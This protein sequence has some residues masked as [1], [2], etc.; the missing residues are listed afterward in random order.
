M[1]SKHLVE[2]LARPGHGAILHWLLMKDPLQA[3]EG[4][5]SASE[6]SPSGGFEFAWAWAHAQASGARQL[7]LCEQP[8]P[9]D[10]GLHYDCVLVSSL[11][12]EGQSPARI[13][14]AAAGALAPGGQLVALLS[15]SASAHEESQS[16][17]ALV[18][19]LHQDFK[20]AG[21]T[22]LTDYVGI[23][24]TKRKSP[25]TKASAPLDLQVVEALEQ[26]LNSYSQQRV[27]DLQATQNL[28]NKQLRGAQR[29]LRK[30][31][32]QLLESAQAQ[33]DKDAERQQLK[34]L[35]SDA[36]VRAEKVKKTLS[37]RLGY[38][39]I[40]RTK[41]LRGVVSLP[42]ALWDVNSEAKR[43]RNGL[44][45]LDLGRKRLKR[46]AQELQGSVMPTSPS[47][48]HRPATKAAKRPLKH[49]EVPPGLNQLQ[50]GADLAKLRVASIMDEFT[51]SSFGPEC[52]V[53]LLDPES[54]QE[55]LAE[56]KPQLLF[57][58]S[59]WRGKDEEW[60]GKI[61]Q[62]SPELE[63][64]IKWSRER[65]NIPTI[66]WCKED[67]VH[68][69][70]FINTA[71]HFDFVFT[72]DI[73]CVHRYKEILGHE[74]IYLLP[75]ACQ[76]KTQ[77][78]I[79]K[80]DRKNAAC[81]AG[82]YY[83]RYPER[84][85]DFLRLVLK[86]LE[87]WP[88]EIFDRN[89][90]K[91]DPGYQFPESFRPL[92]QGTLAFSEI[93]RAYKGYDYAININSIKYSQTMFA[94]RVFEVLASNTVTVSNFSRGIQLMF[95][96]LVIATDDP[97]TLGSRLNAL[98]DNAELQR[99]FK[100]LGLRKVLSEH[101]YQD[102]LAYVAKKV[103]EIESPSLLPR[104]A[105]IG[106]AES[107][108]QFECIVGSFSRQ[109]YPN[110]RLVLIRSEA[111]LDTAVE[112]DDTLVTVI[113]RRA[114]ASEDLTTLFADAD[115]IASFAPEDFYGENY[116]VDLGLATRFFEGAAIGKVARYEWANGQ[117]ATLRGEGSQYRPTESLWARSAIARPKCF[118]A[119]SI[120][121][122]VARAPSLELKTGDAF[123]IDEFSYCQGGGAHRDGDAL[124]IVHGR[125]SA[126]DGGL[127]ISRL[128]DE[129]EKIEPSPAT[130]DLGGE[131]GA[132]QFAQI[133]PS[134]RQDQLT[135]HHTTDGM[136]V[137]SALGQK[138]SEYIYAQE[139]VPLSE[140][141]WAGRA[142]FYLDVSAGA[143]AQVAL[144][145]YD[146]NEKRLGDTINSSLSNHEVEIPAEARLVL[147]GLLISG[148]GQVTINRLM[149]GHALAEDPVR[150]FG[151]S[152]RLVLTNQYPSSADLY[153]N[154][155]VHRRVIKY[156]ERGE[157]VDV[158]RF[159]SGEGLSYHDFEGVTVTTGGEEIL[160]R[161]L[162]TNEYESVLVHFL[163]PA[164]WSVLKSRLDT[165]QVIVWVHGFEIQAWHRR[166]YN[167]ST[168]S[169]VE[170][171]KKLGERR[172]LLWHEV[173]DKVHPNLKLVFVSRHLADEV[174][175][176]MK[177]S[178]PT[179]QVHV[180]HNLIDT[181]LFNYVAKP[182]EQRTQVLS[183]RPF[184]DLTYAN[185]LSVAAILELSD[186]PFFDE[187]DFRIIGDGCL[188]DE[189]VAPLRGF[190]NVI[191]EKR[192]IAQTEITELHKDYGVFLVPSRMDSQGVSRDEAMAS[193]LV[194]I[195]N[196]VAAIPE[197]AD[198]DCAFL[199]PAEDASA[200]A[201]AIEKLYHDPEL[202]QRMSANA[203][204]RVRRQSGP[205]QTIAEELRL[206][207]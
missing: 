3:K 34:Q 175:E 195:T 187:L 184:A 14:A 19:E 61:A 101:T 149:L 89:F 164:M 11:C 88:V 29:E 21:A 121:E 32:V 52:D 134:G 132:E 48:T 178:L 176:D 102:R 70:T 186:K 179:S 53:L 75:F 2:P 94:R 23:V 78:P 105:V 173:L 100:L 170:N 50:T 112:V 79:E 68:F 44:S 197:F 185:D 28:L 35:L 159:S 83:T 33:G 17:V 137:D 20:I 40:H 37:F 163:D 144:I 97:G 148:K 6:E 152:K 116:L 151:R 162:D 191:I 182:A 156:R 140:F 154:V 141:G 203:A 72:T 12:E 66:F 146:A 67:P 129:A 130:T 108:E 158:F 124:T 172:A 181:D 96:D 22:P 165:M 202:F 139:K 118:S 39:L 207:E 38:E 74:R 110:K 42:R 47:S 95:G 150:I 90:G 117:G 133:F 24:A 93:D 5:T 196:A 65:A 167:Y 188:F 169:E 25:L 136:V 71:A 46:F 13:I 56:F 115:Y 55:Q 63:G 113:D 160:E 145:F 123:A 30:R 99:K 199:A 109:S 18:R 27:D 194:P 131:I 26:A 60:Q 73:D 114:Q 153:R 126:F 106:Y 9:E 171:A 86:L 147:F 155:F 104:I 45:V 200:L 189:T 161:L 80:Y 43:R 192:F 64:I 122:Y 103:F 59:A 77:N 58:E 143:N 76:P 91:T 51:L 1:T 98:A 180:I 166:S 119:L 142:R 54:W 10:A 57:V 84:Q 125:L 107:V 16:A 198:E 85:R 111:L 41:S 128:L 206:L 177:L 15:L 7:D 4:G 135:I 82:A 204:A 168:E 205:E 127:P 87:H 31:T 183:I 174:E 157:N 138:M 8:A 69:S 193:G 92:I 190:T 201:A 81:F 120:D 62:V 49:F 36:E